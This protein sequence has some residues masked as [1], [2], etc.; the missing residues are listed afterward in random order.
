MLSHCEHH[1]APIVGK[2]H[3]GVREEFLRYARL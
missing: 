2:A 1:F 3:I